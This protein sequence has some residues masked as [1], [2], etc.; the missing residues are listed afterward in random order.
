MRQAMLLATVLLVAPLALASAQTPAEQ[1]SRA[2]NQEVARD[3]MRDLADEARGAD[4]A[5]ATPTPAP[6]AV[7]RQLDVDRGAIRP[8]VGRPE[9]L[10]TAPRSTTTG[11][12]NL[13]R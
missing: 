12:G 4:T 5:P 9:A 7:A 3:R 13:T 1:A 2:L 10:G 11:D 6:N 8:D